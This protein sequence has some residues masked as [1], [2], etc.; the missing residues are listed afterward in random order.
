MP[1][2]STNTICAS[3]SV[4]TPCIDVRVVCGLSATMATFWPTIAFSSVDLPAFGRPIS[5][6][7]PDLKLLFMRNRLRPADA[8]PLHA[9]LVACQHFDPYPVVFHKFSWF[10]HSPQH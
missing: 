5:E 10:G 6:T 3:G 1:G 2:V 9:Q 7:N 4:T 8:N